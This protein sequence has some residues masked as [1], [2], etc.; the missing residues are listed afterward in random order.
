MYDLLIYVGALTALM[1]LS[2]AAGNL[3]GYK[4]GIYTLLREMR[5]QKLLFNVSKGKAFSAANSKRS[6]KTL[7]AN[8]Q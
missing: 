3:I 8:K 7:S 2:F 1:C 5:E 6:R 4:Q